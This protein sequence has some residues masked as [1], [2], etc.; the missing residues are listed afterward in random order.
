ML[1]RCCGASK[2]HGTVDLRLDRIGYLQGMDLVKGQHDASCSDAVWGLALDHQK[3]IGRE[4][5]DKY[6]LLAKLCDDD[7]T[8]VHVLGPVLKETPP[9]LGVIHEY[10][11]PFRHDLSIAVASVQRSNEALHR[12]GAMGRCP[13]DLVTTCSSPVARISAGLRFPI[14]PRRLDRG[15]ISDRQRD[16]VLLR[17]LRKGQA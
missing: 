5:T 6:N 1:L 7:T 15:V 8:A 17:N 3:R 4:E 10:R 9:D 11:L 2:S 13:S 12:S 16:R 14:V